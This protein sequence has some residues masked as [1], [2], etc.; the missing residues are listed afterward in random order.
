M[1]KPMVGLITFGDERDDMWQK[2]FQSMTEPRHDEAIAYLQTLPVELHADRE[3]ARTREQINAQVDHLKKSRVDVLMAHIPCWTSPNLVVHGI[4]RLDKPVVII[5][6][7][8]TATHGMVGFLGTGGALQQIGKTHCRIREDFHTDAMTRKLLPFLRAAAAVSA[9]KGEVF[10]FFG[11]R[12]LGIDTGSF[13][14]MQW[15]KMFQVDVE[16]VD[17][18]EIIRRAESI[19]ETRTQNMVKWLEEKTKTV[20]YDEKVLT[21]DKLAYQVRCYLATRDIIEEKN[22]GFVAI[23]CMPDLTAHH[24]PQ[25]LSAA[26]LPDIHDADGEKKPIS[27]ACEAD[28]D[29]ALTMEILK[30]VSNGNPPM[31]ADLSHM[32]HDDNVLYLPNCG[33]M[34]TWF[35]GRSDKPEENLKQVELRPSV[36]PAGGSSVYFTAAPGPMTLARLYRWDGQYRMAII[37][38]DA[39]TLSQE[40][41]DAFIQAR[42]PHQLPTAFVKVNADLDEIIE[43]FGS[44][45][46]SGVAGHYVDELVELCRMTGITPVVFQ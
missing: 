29:G 16:H 28:G 22:L 1:S 43:E 15:R 10:G 27:M 33:A 39:V 21:P 11:G 12:S 3:V 14:P 37:P 24:I 41:Q 31:F 45:H 9:L 8:S 2:V 13:D 4:Q 26:F 18:L 44:N 25:C 19:D 20:L 42:G 7:K 17:Q 6:S 32:D 35:A 46:I 36:R 38:G 5:T 34:C 40:K 30:H 23:K